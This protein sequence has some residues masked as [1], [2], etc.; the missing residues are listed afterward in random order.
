MA[1]N[2]SDNLLLLFAKYPEPG[3]VKTR[4]GKV[5]GYE[6]AARLYRAFLEDLIVKFSLCDGHQTYD[7]RWVYINSEKSFP[8]FVHKIANKDSNYMSFA[9]YNKP[10]LLFHQ[11]DQFMWAEKQGYKRVVGISTDVPQIPSNY[12][13]ETFSILETH[14]V[15]IGPTIDG[16]YY[17][18]GSHPSI[19]VQE[20]IKMSTNHVFEDI[21]KSIRIS[22]LKSYVLPKLV[23]VDELVDV[24]HLAEI[25]KN[26]TSNPCPKTWEIIQRICF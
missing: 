9:P 8:N 17:L 11:L 16:G 21:Q 5:I 25:I 1:K 22:K 24:H 26:D 12:V 14:D 18:L 3:L 15:V 10:G 2:T 19:T 23:D 20:N 7:V 6:A 4:L 13:I